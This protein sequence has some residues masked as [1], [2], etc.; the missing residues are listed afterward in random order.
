MRVP[1]VGPSR[2]NATKIRI[3]DNTLKAGTALSPEVRNEQSS[4]D[5]API[6][7]NRLG[8]YFS[9]VDIVNEDIVYSIADLSF[10]DLIGDTRDEFKQSDRTLNKLQRDYFKRYN[11]SNKFWDYSRILSFYC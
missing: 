4:Q 2:R 1:N 11:R 9:P 3:E 6:D 7:S 8:I 10:D 5:F